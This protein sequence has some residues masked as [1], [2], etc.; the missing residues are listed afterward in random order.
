MISSAFVLLNR[1]I[2]PWSSRVLNPRMVIGTQ[3]KQATSYP[4]VQPRFSSGADE[5][6]L[7]TETVSL[8]ECKWMLDAEN[9]GVEKTF[10]FPTYAKA[11]VIQSSGQPGRPPD[12]HAGLHNSCGDRVQVKESSS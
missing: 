7:L 1:R 4:N 12:R 2:H 9:M 5:N 3:V 10:N 8:L 11:L 6:Q